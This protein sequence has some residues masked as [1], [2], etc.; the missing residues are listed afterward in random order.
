MFHA[1]LYS[2]FFVFRCY[3]KC[4]GTQDFRGGDF[5]SSTEDIS[6]C[7]CGT[8]LPQ[9][10]IDYDSYWSQTNRHKAIKPNLLSILRFGELLYLYHLIRTSVIWNHTSYTLL[11][12]EGR[13]DAHAKRC[14]NCPPISRYVRYLCNICNL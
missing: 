11:L 14:Q 13:Y 7:T 9:V 3:F 10:D 4:G 12:H 6:T 2:H 8:H 1:K 5:W